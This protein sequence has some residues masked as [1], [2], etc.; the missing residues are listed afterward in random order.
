MRAGKSIE[1]RLQALEKRFP[2][3]KWD[4]REV[5]FEDLEAL[6]HVLDP[7]SDSTGKPP[8]FSKR[9]LRLISKLEADEL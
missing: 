2:P 4:L 8:K 1:R 6:E 9:L 5:S 3:R 7:G